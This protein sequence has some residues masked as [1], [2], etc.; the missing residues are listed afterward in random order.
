MYNKEYATF[1]S[2]TVDNSKTVEHFWP[3]DSLIGPQGSQGKQGP[4]G[5]QGIEGPQGPKGPQGDALSDIRNSNLDNLTL[6]FNNTTSPW[7]KLDIKPTTLYGDRVNTANI[8]DPSGNKYIT[9]SN[10]MFQNPYIVPKNVGQDATIR[11]GKAGGIDTGTWW[12]SGVTTRG[13]F[14]IFKENNPNTGLILNK[15]NGGM[16]TYGIFNANAGM[17]VSGNLNTRGEMNTYGNVNVRSG[18]D[19]S[20]NLNFNSGIFNTRGEMNT[21][22][23]VNVRNVMNTYGNF[24]VRN[25]MDI[26]GN[27][28]L[29]SGNLNLNNDLFIRGVKAN[30]IIEL[31]IKSNQMTVNSNKFIYDINLTDIVGLTI[32]PLKTRVVNLYAYNTSAPATGAYPTPP[33][34]P[35]QTGSN[36]AGVGYTIVALPGQTESY[37]GF[38]PIA[39]SAENENIYTGVYN[40]IYNNYISLQ[41]ITTINETLV[42][43]NKVSTFI[44][45]PIPTTTP[46]TPTRL[47]YN[48]IRYESVNNR[49]VTIIFEL[50]S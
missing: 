17:D 9:M 3:F 46:P 21:Y 41:R 50:L 29:Y 27:L 44:I 36:G 19:V 26:S 28:N 34:S 30:N 4:Q 35:G 49:P 24:N 18:M 8:N 12:E 13:D 23:N 1:N 48:I 40:I 20:G 16:N 42:G 33:L 22:G 10:M 38:A 6:N 25:G 43:A 5:L 2:K 7:T 39:T 37:Y 31:S 15:D 47:D 11:Y 45:K 32:L 14:Q